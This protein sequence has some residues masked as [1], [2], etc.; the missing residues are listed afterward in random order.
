M[1]YMWV[2]QFLTYPKPAFIATCRYHYR[3]ARCEYL[4]RH[5]EST[6]VLIPI[7]GNPSVIWLAPDRD[8][9]PDLDRA[10]AVLLDRRRGIVLNPGLW[11]RYAYPVV[12]TADF[13]YVSARVDPEDDIERV[14]IERDHGTVLEWYFDAPAGDGVQLDTWRRRAPSAVEGRPR[15]GPR[16]WRGHRPERGRLSPFRCTPS[17]P[18]EPRA[19]DRSRG[20]RAPPWRVFGVAAVIRTGGVLGRDR[21][22]CLCARVCH[23]ARTRSIFGGSRKAL[24]SPSIP[25]PGPNRRWWP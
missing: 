19:R 5:P 20:G 23:A 24:R 8:G 16:R 15:L 6:V 2:H 25:G 17:V 10:E 4:Q 12:D 21:V 1:A 18:W 11:I 3:G 7:D 22:G 9:L 14:Y 13:A